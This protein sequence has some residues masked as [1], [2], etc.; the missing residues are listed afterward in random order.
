MASGVSYTNAV[1]SFVT[2]WQAG[3]VKDLAGALKSLDK[4]LD[5]QVAQAKGGGVP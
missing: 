3:T 1:Q 4:Q 5:A 2:K